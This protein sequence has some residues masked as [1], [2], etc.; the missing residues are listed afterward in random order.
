MNQFLEFIKEHLTIVQT[1]FNWLRKTRV[2]ALFEIQMDN[3]KS[4]FQSFERK[5]SELLI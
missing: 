2:I 5:M 4:G 3:D 1:K